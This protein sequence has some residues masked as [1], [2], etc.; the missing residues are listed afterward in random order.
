[1]NL[2]EQQHWDNLYNTKAEDE[3]SWFQPYPKTSMEFVELSDPS[4]LFV[5]SRTIL[6][7]HNIEIN[8]HFLACF[9][10]NGSIEVQYLFN[11]FLN[12]SKTN[13]AWRQVYNYYSSH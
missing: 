2:S 4:P 1:M 11:T 3:V 9:P 13:T 10:R 6:H 8:V 7:K 12:H 5:S